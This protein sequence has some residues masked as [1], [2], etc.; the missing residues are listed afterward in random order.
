VF[1]YLTHDDSLLSFNFGVL[2]LLPY[3]ARSAFSFS[4]SFRCLKRF[5]DVILWPLFFF[6]SKIYW[7]FSLCHFHMDVQST[8]NLCVRHFVSRL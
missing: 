4:Y 8:M 6:Q 3:S 7:K 1:V 5:C 2:V